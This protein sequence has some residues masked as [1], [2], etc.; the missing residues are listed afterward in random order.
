MKPYP[1]SIE[2]S[3][4]GSQIS[5]P[6]G[7]AHTQNQGAQKGREHE[8]SCGSDQDMQAEQK[9]ELIQPGRRDG[10]RFREARTTWA[11]FRSRQIPEP[12]QKHNVAQIAAPAFIS[13]FLKAVHWGLT[14]RKTSGFPKVHRFFVF[15]DQPTE[16][17]NRYHSYNVPCLPRRFSCFIKLQKILLACESVY[18]SWVIE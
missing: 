15:L 3:R 2:I 8:H 10:P 18:R 5:I 6:P 4:H 17:Q 16:N 14:G 13:D 11:H 9:P 12:T 7:P 1:P